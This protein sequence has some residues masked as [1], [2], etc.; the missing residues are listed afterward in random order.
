MLRTFDNC[1]QFH[2]GSSCDSF[3]SLTFQFSI[4]THTHTIPL[5]LRPLSMWPGHAKGSSSYRLVLHN[6]NMSIHLTVLTQNILV[7]HPMTSSIHGWNTPTFSPLIFNIIM[8]YMLYSPFNV[9]EERKKHPEISSTSHTCSI[10]GWRLV[11]VIT[12]RF[13]CTLWVAHSLTIMPVKSSLLLPS[14]HVCCINETSSHQID[15]FFSKYTNSQ[16]GF[17]RYVCNLCEQTHDIQTKC[18]KTELF[19]KW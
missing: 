8:L 5:P 19:I 10:L 12:K 14:Q 2:C 7:C 11:P 16:K 15:H 18:S 17:H 4:Y 13:L 6:Y 9:S 3:L 1:E